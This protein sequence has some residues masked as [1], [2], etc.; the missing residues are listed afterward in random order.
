MKI[1][2]RPL[3]E[4]ARMR[5]F[6]LV[7]ITAVLALFGVLAVYL[8]AFA[9]ERIP[10]VVRSVS[11]FGNSYELPAGE[12]PA[13]EHS[14]DIKALRSFSKVFVNLAKKVKPAVVYI[15]VKKKADPAEGRGF[16][17]IPEEFFGP[18]FRR[19]MPRFQE[20]AGSG[21]IVDK[22]KGYVITNNH[23]VS[24][25]EEIKIIT[26]D[27][28]EFAGKVVGVHKDS[29]VAVVQFTD[30]S[31][32]DKD[33]IAQVTFG[34]SDKVEVGDWVVAIGA[35]FQLPQTLTVG[36]VSALGR[37]RIIG[38][39]TALEDFIQTDAAINPGNSGGPL[40][41]LDGQVIGI[42]TAISS[43]SGS[44][45]GIGF[46][47]PSNIARNIAEALINTGK[48]ER[49]F[50]GI[51]G[52]D[53][54]GLSPEMLEKIGADRNQRGAIIFSVLPGSPGERAGLQ[55]YDIIL[56]MDGEPLRNFSQL[57]TRVAFVA[58]GTTVKLKVLRSGSTKNVDLVIGSSDEFK[59]QDEAG[60][61]GSSSSEEPSV[62]AERFGFSLRALDESTRRS[63]GVAAEK[64][65]L[66]TAVA[67]GG[68]AAGFGF[69][70]G[71]VIVEV[72][73]VPAKSP[74]E[75]V[76]QLKDAEESGKEVLFLVERDRRNQ[77]IVVSLR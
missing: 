30:M 44:S 64:G 21:F 54:H 14:A 19:R 72:N 4:V 41:G 75:V 47:V 48:V 10:D 68:P 66:I 2:Q 20:G 26:N 40:L 53:A 50:I 35:P 16:F 37:E 11:A 51:T 52:Q 6:L 1:R 69:R 73:R 71:D 28:R 55:P 33:A 57:R 60:D 24:G 17:G 59:P 29:D 46:A 58:P 62:G 22:E 38:G 56:E 49:G 9:P 74:E 34:D 45:A 7:S 76:N 67:E 42:N 32:V 5:R 39:A 12:E 27:E 8:L 15:Q 25:A 43:S 36:V 3:M 18:Q 31:K 23:V 13:E 77:L 61:G 63:A 70:V 65:V